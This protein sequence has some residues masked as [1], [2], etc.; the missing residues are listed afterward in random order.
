M[1][2]KERTS[3]SPSGETEAATEADRRAEPRIPHRSI[4]VM[5]FGEGVRSQ[6]EKAELLD[7][8]AK[9]VG[10]IVSQALQPRIRFF[11][12]LKLTAIALVIY[13]VRNCQQIT[14]G[15][16]IGAEFVGVIGN[17]ADRAATP[18]RVLNA[19]LAT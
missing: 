11:L 12:K 16:R 6:F 17:E 15:Y 14:E 8:S 4:V 3:A 10:L 9:G 19:L 5:P 18:E 2:S 7:C 1:K 13:E